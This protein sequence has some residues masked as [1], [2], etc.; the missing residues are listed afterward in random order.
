MTV[1]VLDYGLGNVG[2]VANMLRRVDNEPT[3]VR[4]PEHVAEADRLLLPGVG[5]FDAAVTLLQQQGMMDAIREFAAT[6][7]PLLG[8]CLGM[9]LLC[10]TSDEG[11]MNGLGLIPGNSVRFSG[12]S[13]IRVPHMGWN[14]VAPTT[15]EP[16]VR[17]ITPDSRFYFVHSYHVV[18]AD[19]SDVLATTPY[20]TPFTS[21]VRSENVIGAQFHPEKSH[22]FGM[23]LLKNFGAL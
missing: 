2:S 6:G 14:R 16:I 4:Q 19:E 3:I 21:M 9:Q 18:T 5:S 8:I 7:R 10:D 23:Q 20:G 22:T 17:D 12:Q 11:T 1:S 13:G 15:D